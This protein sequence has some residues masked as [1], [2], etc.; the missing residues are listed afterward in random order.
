MKH[1]GILAGIT[2]LAAAGACSGKDSATTDSAYGGTTTGAI[3]PAPSMG[4]TTGVG[5]TTGVGATT[6]IDTTRRDTTAA[7]KP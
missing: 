5:M 2:F 3:T 4:T 1:L 7:K 6:R